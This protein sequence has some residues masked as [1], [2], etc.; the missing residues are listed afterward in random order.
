VDSNRSSDH[1]PGG[2]IHHPYPLAALGPVSLMSPLLAPSVVAVTGG[3]SSCQVALRHQYPSQCSTLQHCDVIQH[4]ASLTGGFYT[5]KKARR[6]TPT[7]LQ[8]PGVGCQAM[9]AHDLGKR[10]FRARQGTRSA[11]A[12]KNTQA[13]CASCAC[14]L[15]L[16]LLVTWANSRAAGEIP[17]RIFRYLSSS[18][19]G[20]IRSSRQAGR[21][22]RPAMRRSGALRAAET[23]PWPPRRRPRASRP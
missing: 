6:F 10:N 1:R 11:G 23:A 20:F 7:S 5:R 8:T 13:C 12:H 3:A 17:W 16:A 18:F 19:A 2:Y 14:F 4:G 15:F 9:K 22:P 21:Y